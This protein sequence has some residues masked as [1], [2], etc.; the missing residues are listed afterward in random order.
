MAL[1]HQGIIFFFAMQF[2]LANPNA[3]KRGAEEEKERER[4]EAEMTPKASCRMA[5]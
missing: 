1:L 5:V 3:K 2:C 4:E